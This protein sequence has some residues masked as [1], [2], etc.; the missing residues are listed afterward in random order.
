M[1]NRENEAFPPLNETLYKLNGSLMI[2]NKNLERIAL[3]LEKK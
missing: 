3:A 2:L 1:E